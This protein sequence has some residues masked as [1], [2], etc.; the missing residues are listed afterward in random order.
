MRE[1]FIF[2]GRR[3]RDKKNES[4]AEGSPTE[5]RHRSSPVN[6]RKGIRSFFILTG[7]SLMVMLI[8]FLYINVAS[9]RLKKKYKKMNR[10]E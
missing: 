5:E 10:E 6:S 1:S 8:G 9:R 3:A 7:I 4:Q 2:F